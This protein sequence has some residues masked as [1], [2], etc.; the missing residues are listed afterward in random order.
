MRDAG[1][2]KHVIE[3]I[4][5]KLANNELLLFFFKPNINCVD[6][7][8]LYTPSRKHTSKFEH[9]W[10]HRCLFLIE[11]ICRNKNIKRD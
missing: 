2:N 6:N 3:N 10:I 7:W 4:T 9:P 5:Y 11:D 1:F 8:C